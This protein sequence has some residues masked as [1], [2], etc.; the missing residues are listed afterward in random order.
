[1]THISFSGNTLEL[2]LENKSSMAAQ[3]LQICDNINT[4][5]VL[6]QKSKKRRRGE[7]RQ[8]QTGNKNTS[9]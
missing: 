5:K 9:T 1:M 7:T 2:A 6:K 8:W 3:Y 4:N